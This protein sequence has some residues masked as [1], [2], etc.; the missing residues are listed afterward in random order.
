MS[1]KQ[2]RRNT[3]ESN[4]SSVHTITMCS[5]DEYEKWK[6]GELYFNKWDD[7]FVSKEDIKNEVIKDTSYTGSLTD[8]EEMLVFYKNYY[9]SG[10]VTEEEYFNNCDYET[11][12][13]EY[14]T[15]SGETVVAFGYY[16]EDR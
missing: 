1:R 4:S 16:G 2:I 10:I 11:Y 9:E 15:N 13:E 12:C 7:Y 5:I 8:F 14:K 6:R 3:F